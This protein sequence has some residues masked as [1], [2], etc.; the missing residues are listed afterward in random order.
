MTNKIKIDIISDVVCP[1]CIVGYKRLEKAMQELDVKD[2]F[3]IEWNP[4]E[5]NP[6]MEPEGEDIIEHMSR[7][8][9]MSEEK[10]LQNQIDIKKTFDEIGFPFEYYKGK[11]VVS[12]RD[13][14]ILLHYAKEE[15][16]QTELKIAL[17]KA[18]F[19]E[20]K[21][22][23]DRKVLEEIVKS[24]GLNTKE[25]MLRLD[26]TNAIKQIEDKE[27]YWRNLGISSVPAMVFNTKTSINGAHPVETYKKLLTDLLE[28][29]I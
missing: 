27:V 23:S 11:K 4:F 25:A 15:N 9:G 29:K 17:F 16:K 14:H 13:A 5:L 18:N 21:D 12:T 26:D 1:W 22:V 28:G 8:Y 6:N 24:V 7:K 2:K 10:A 3:E 19:G 20:K